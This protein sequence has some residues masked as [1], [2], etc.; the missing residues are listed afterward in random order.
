MN[1][2]TVRDS[3]P[4]FRS[5]SSY[6]TWARV[7]QRDYER[8]RR[9]VSHH[10]KTFLNEYG[11]TNPAEFF[12]VAT[13]YFFEKPKELRKLHPELYRELKFFYQQDPAEL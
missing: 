5:Q 10:R 6:I 7:L 3:T 4:A 9:D 12:A 11:A 1:F 13:E 8:L 2:C